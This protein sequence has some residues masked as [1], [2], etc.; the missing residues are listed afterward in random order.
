MTVFRRI[1]AVFRIHPR[2]Y[3]YL[4]LHVNLPGA[5]ELNVPDNTWIT[6]LIYLG[7]KCI[8]VRVCAF[9]RNN[10]TVTVHIIYIYMYLYDTS[11]HFL[12]KCY[13]NPSNNIRATT[14]T[15]K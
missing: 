3:T 14:K 10:N 9:R 5:N 12:Y 4:K 1:S 7:V 6:M 8:S 2:Y 11:F 13:N 15:F